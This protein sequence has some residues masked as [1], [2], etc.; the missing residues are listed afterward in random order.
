LKQIIPR[1]NPE[2]GQFYSGNKTIRQE[3]ERFVKTYAVPRAGSAAIGTGNPDPRFM[4][5]DDILGT[6]RDPLFP[7]VGCFETKK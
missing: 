1:I 6:P 7:N 5:A 3:F 2:T 4:P